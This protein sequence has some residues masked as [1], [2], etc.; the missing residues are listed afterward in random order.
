MALLQEFLERK[1][2]PDKE[3]VTEFAAAEKGAGE[4]SRREKKEEV[5]E[6][7]EGRLEAL[8]RLRSRRREF[9]V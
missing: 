7:P 6:G 9:S 8:S 1:G 3:N 2:K 5:G 4:S